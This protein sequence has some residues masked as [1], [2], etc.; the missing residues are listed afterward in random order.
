MLL[1]D[2]VLGMNEHFTLDIQEFLQ[3]SVQGR[4]LTSTV[5]HEFA[6]YMVANLLYLMVEEAAMENLPVLDDVEDD[7]DDDEYKEDDFCE[8]DEEEDVEEV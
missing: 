5:C 3:K 2:H 7:E 1:V 4:Q 8:E 6:R